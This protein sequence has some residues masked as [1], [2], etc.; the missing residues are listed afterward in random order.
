MGFLS[1]GV[2]LS[3]SDLY[4]FKRHEMHFNPPESFDVKTRLSNTVFLKAQNHNY[5]KQ[6]PP[7]NEQKPT[8]DNDNI[9]FLPS[10]GEKKKSSFVILRS[11]FSVIYLNKPVI[12]TVATLQ[13]VP[14]HSPLY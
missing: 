12:Y 7:Q 10:S 5:L 3:A 1:S 9:S 13:N 11:T 2:V 6:P 14:L 8:L 4:F